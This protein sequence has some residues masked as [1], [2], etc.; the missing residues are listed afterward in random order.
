MGTK[1]ESAVRAINEALVQLR[2]DKGITLEE[3]KGETK[4]VL[5]TKCLAVYDSCRVSVLMERHWGFVVRTAG[6]SC[7]FDPVRA[8][9]KGT[10]QSG[11]LEV[12]AVRG[13]HGTLARG[14]E[15]EAD[16]TVVA[17]ERFKTLEIIADEK[18]IDRWP[19][20]VRRAFIFALARDLAIPVTGRTKDLETMNALYLGALKQAA[21][22]AACETRVGDSAWGNN[23]YADAIR[24]RGWHGRTCGG[25]R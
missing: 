10:V 25:C 23:D 22:H 8:K 20:L 5:A 14:W 24:G 4:T 9:W 13:F 11:V 2:Q 3:F 16:G 15:L 1:E 7:R 19:P 18:N 21:I 17:D 12:K 6:V